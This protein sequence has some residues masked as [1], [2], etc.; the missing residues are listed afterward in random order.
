M[1][2]CVSNEERRKRKGGRQINTK[3]VRTVKQYT[4]GEVRTRIYNGDNKA[5]YRWVFA[6]NSHENFQAGLLRDAASMK[7]GNFDAII[8]GTRRNKIKQKRS[9][10][11]GRR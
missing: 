7:L 9:Q 4:N 8:Q 1:H 11:D 10:K 3:S 5:E 6:G 2:G